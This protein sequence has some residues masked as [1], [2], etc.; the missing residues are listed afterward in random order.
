MI[1][2][3]VQ[4][5]T[6]ENLQ[7]YIELFDDEELELSLVGEISD[8]VLKFDIEGARNI[9]HALKSSP[10]QK[11]IEIILDESVNFKGTCHVKK[12]KINFTNISEFELSN[13]VEDSLFYKD[14]IVFLS[15]YHEAIDATIFKLEECIEK[16]VFSPAEIIDLYYE[17][18]EI[19]LYGEFV[20]A[21]E[22]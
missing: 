1:I 21:G 22:R 3:E 11:G 17:N 7:E 13:V 2:L 10:I 19:T 4:T 5:Y 18:R 6:K 9:L 8:L 15:F 12:V 20:H 14:G 16:Y